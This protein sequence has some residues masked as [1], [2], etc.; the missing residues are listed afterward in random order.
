MFI[1]SADGD[2][3]DGEQAQPYV[4][5][6]E[7]LG[8]SGTYAFTPTNG[9]LPPGLSI[10]GDGILSGQPTDT[11]LFSFDIHVYDQVN[12]YSDQVSFSIRVNRYLCC[13][14]Y[15]GGITGNADCDTD[16]KINL[17]DITALIDRVYI[18]MENLCC[19]ENGNVDGDAQGKINL[20]DITRLISYVYLSGTPMAS[21]P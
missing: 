9:S 21:C 11:G 13:G 20:T 4:D 10:D 15:T 12:G 14:K 18:T 5:T 1:I 2:L 16:G 6:V 19:E 8:G 17:P 7:V 3:G